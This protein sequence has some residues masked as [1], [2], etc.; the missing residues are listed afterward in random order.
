MKNKPNFFVITG[1]SQTG[2]VGGGGSAAWEF[3]PLN[4]VFSDNVPNGEHEV[5]LN[6]SQQSE[7]RDDKVSSVNTDL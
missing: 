1:V 7:I 4:P 2:G 6:L 3:F 5:S